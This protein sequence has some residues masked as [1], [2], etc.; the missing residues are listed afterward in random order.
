VNDSLF[1]IL[2][3]PIRFL[4]D[5]YR[6]AF[7][8]DIAPPGVDQFP[9]SQS[10]IDS[11]GFDPCQFFSKIRRDAFEFLF[12]KLLSLFTSGEPLVELRFLHA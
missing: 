10:G 3:L 1:I 4:A 11:H 2:W 5:A 9:S 8:V 7:K 6:L 12:N